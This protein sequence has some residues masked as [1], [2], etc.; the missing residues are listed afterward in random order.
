VGIGV[1]RIAQ[2][3]LKR[4]IGV[5]AERLDC[6]VLPASEAM[7]DECLEVARELRTAGLAV[8]VDLMGRSLTKAISYAD[9][10]E[11]ELIVIVGAKDLAAGEVTIRDMRT[12]VQEKVQKRELVE[13][14][15]KH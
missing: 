8:D 13:R 4:K 9:S 2:I 10:R 5:A 1:D 3:L 7:L 15:R 14:L 6:M 11:A 12:G